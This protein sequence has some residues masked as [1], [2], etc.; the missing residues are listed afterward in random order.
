MAEIK[1][2]MSWMQYAE[3]RDRVLQLREELNKY[4]SEFYHKKWLERKQ[5]DFNSTQ[6]TPIS[7]TEE[8]SYISSLQFFNHM[9]KNDID[10]GHDWTCA[11]CN[12]S[13][14]S[15]AEQCTKCHRERWPQAFID[16][17]QSKMGMFRTRVAMTDPE[18]QRWDQDFIHHFPESQ[19]PNCTC[20]KRK[21]GEKG[22]KGTKKHKKKMA[23]AAAAD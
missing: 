18:K 4:K 6:Q 20:S 3:K 22:D 10:R 17:L 14:P 9:L 2:S 19:I 8:D 15:A 11:W 16:L 21:E 1:D 5:D 12:T 23:A 7:T 13:H